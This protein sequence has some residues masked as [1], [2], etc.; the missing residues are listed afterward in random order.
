[1][2]GQAVGVKAEEGGVGRRD[3]NA[4]GLRQEAHPNLGVALMAELSGVWSAGKQILP[5]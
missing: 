1:V 2:G 4:K 5:V 3:F